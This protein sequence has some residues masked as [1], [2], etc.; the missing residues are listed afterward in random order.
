MLSGIRKPARV[1]VFISGGGSTL[2]ALLEMHHQFDIKLII[3]NR[4]KALGALKAKR[5][6]K[7]I[8]YQSSQ[9][10]FAEIEEILKVNRIEKIVLAGYMKILPESF[11]KKWSGKIIN[12]HPSLL[13]AYPGLE[14]AERSWTD[15]KPMGVSLHTVIPAI[16]AGPIFLQQTSSFA[17]EKLDLAN[18]LIWLRRTEQHLLR[19]L[20]LRWI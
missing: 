8:F 7:T 2:Q 5:F 17:E 12:I 14:S 18:S 16:D 9:T 15:L 10:I 13:P 4:K 11:V 6:G 1:A 19:E 3:C 20:S